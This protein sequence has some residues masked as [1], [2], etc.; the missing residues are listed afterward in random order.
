[1]L[2]QEQ[3]SIGGRLDSSQIFSGTYHELS[4]SVDGAQKVHWDMD[5]V[6]TNGEV[7]S[8]NGNF[9]F[10]T[11]GDVVSNSTITDEDT[12]I[13]IDVLA[14]DYDVDG[15]TLS[16]TQ[17]QGQNIN[18]D[19]SVIITDSSGNMIGTA[20][21]VDGKIQFNPD[22]VLK[23]LNT[24]ETQDVVFDYTVSDGLTTDTANVTITITGNDDH[25]VVLN[26]NANYDDTFSDTID[27]V[28]IGGNGSTTVWSGSGNDT[29]IGGDGNDNLRGEFGNDTI[30]G[31]LGNDKLY[32]DGNEGSGSN[33]SYDPNG[34]DTLSGGA[35][36]DALYGGAGDDALYGGTGNDFLSGDTGSDILSGGAGDDEIVF[37]EIDSSIDGGKG[38]DTLIIDENVT[39]DLSIVSDK[40]SNIEILDLNQGDQNITLHVDD[41]LKVTDTDNLLRIV[42]D[43]NDT[44]NL[45]S[46]EWKLGSFK[47][48]AETGHGNVMEY[49]SQADPTVTIEIDDDI[50][51]IEN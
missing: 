44:I 43:S 37:D 21:V 5:K 45:D 19:G 25:T 49:I 29:I 18:A 14:N 23:A 17:I 9:N 28:I 13:T 20:Q 3:D 48:D 10:R 39:L 35:G 8:D 4:V 46:A 36:D 22:G 47:T 24:G 32:G 30:D 31:G 41:V 26:N 1:M 38:L 33:Y 51:I 50:T 42:G 11:T 16:I 6:E 12:S 15:D 7:V 34:A 2:G 27:D 40:I